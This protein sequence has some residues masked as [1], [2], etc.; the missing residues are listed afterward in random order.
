MG[1]AWNP[2]ADSPSSPKKRGLKMPQ[3][4]IHSHQ[5][6]PGHEG[7][8]LGELQT[9]QESSHQPWPSGDRNACKPGERNLC[10]P[11]SLI[12]N[13][14]NVQYVLP[15]RQLWNHPSI[16]VMD[17]YLRGH[18]IGEDLTIDANHRGGGLIAGTLD[19]KHRGIHQLCYWRPESV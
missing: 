1:K 15:R 10:L 6:A 9:H 13:W 14:Y 19:A 11:K 8:R 18:D 16:F 12:H 5:L 4:M 17:R 3:K 7:K 2:M